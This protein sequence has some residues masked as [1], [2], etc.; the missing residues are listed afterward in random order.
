MSKTMFLIIAFFIAASCSSSKSKFAENNDEDVYVLHDSENT[1]SDSDV[2]DSYSEKDDVPDNEETLPDEENM[3]IDK[4]NQ[5]ADFDKLPDTD[6]EL[7]GTEQCEIEEE[8]FDEGQKSPYHLCFVCDVSE[9]K[10]DWTP[11][12]SGT[13][14]RI[15]SGECDIAEKC[16]GIS[17]TCPDDVFKLVD[18]PCGDSSETECDKP[19]SCDGYGVCRKNYVEE[20]TACTDD[21]DDCNGPESCDGSGSCISQGPDVVCGDREICNPDNGECVC[22]EDNSFF[23]SPDKTF[24]A[25][26]GNN[27]YP[28]KQSKCYNETEEIACPSYESEL[29]FF[30]QDAQY[31][32]NPSTFTISGESPDQ[33]VT[34]SLTNLTWELDVDYTK[35][36]WSSAKAYCTSKGDDWRLPTIK[37]LMTT[38]HFDYWAPACDTEYCPGNSGFFW[39]SN[40]DLEDSSKALNIYFYTGDIRS[41]DKTD[42][43]SLYVRCVKGAFFDPTGTIS[44]NEDVNEPVATDSMTGLSWTKTMDESATWEEALDGCETL[45]YGNYND[46]RLPNI[47]ELISVIKYNSTSITTELPNIETASPHWTSTTYSGMENNAFYFLF[48]SGKNARRKKTHKIKY[49]CVR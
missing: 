44:E 45:N 49:I 46:W 37:E 32:D 19:D 31:T 18:E 12:E 34:D 42:T 24:C 3:D 10:F 36:D 22:D 1:I 5:D 23:I 29:P 13:I 17:G 16:D 4:N 35:R 47:H 43:N 28:T 11:V 15:S 30:G 25:F 48:T 7:C 8:C 33:V 14:C 20:F 38:L 40:E 39:S 26:A 9:N 6:P 21:G 41:K 27:I 2:V